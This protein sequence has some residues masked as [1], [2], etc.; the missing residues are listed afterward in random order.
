MAKAFTL[1][2]TTFNEIARIDNT[3]AD[4]EGQTVLP[5]RIIIV[6][7]GSN[8]GT[9]EKLIAWKQTSK[10]SVEI[11]LIPKSKIAEAR[12]HAIGL[13][14]TDIVASTDFGCRYHSEWLESI[15]SPFNDDTIEITGG[16]FTVREDDVKNLSQ[17]ADYVLQNGYKTVIDGNFPASSRSIAY[18]KYVWEQIGG[19]QEWLTMA[20]DDLIFWK[21][22]RKRN[23]KVKL[24]DKPYVYWSRHKTF[25]AFGKE[26][27]RYGL[28]D[29]E[30]GVNKRTLISHIVETSLRYSLFIH[31]LLIP[32]YIGFTSLPLIFLLPQLFGLRSYANAFKRWLQWRSPKYNI[33]VFLAMLW[34]IEVSRINYIRG[35]LKGISSRTSVQKEGA[36]K[37]MGELG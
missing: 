21:Q 23:F 2:S 35:H 3:I 9:Y 34:M 16:S 31:I 29:G 11:I 28:G 26:A 15:I 1:V 10:T 36:K 19:Y 4:I 7:A 27:R 20:A 5:A 18:R 24:V 14:T 25:K 33:K 12:N 22:I 8:D 6:D 13:A 30:G 17:R 32:F 37:L